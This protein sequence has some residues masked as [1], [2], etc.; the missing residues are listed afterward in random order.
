MIGSFLNIRKISDVFLLMK[1]TSAMIIFGLVVFS[2]LPLAAAE[3]P[4]AAPTVLPSTRREMKTAGFWVS[5]NR[6]PDR[7]VLDEAAV[8]RLNAF[9]RDELKSVKDLSL[10]PAQYSGA[11]LRRELNDKISELGQK[12]YFLEDGRAAQEDF[13]ADVR[14]KSD[15]ESIPEKINVSYGVIVHFADQRFLPTEKGLTAQAGDVDFDE[16]QNSDLDVSTPVVV[17]HKSADGQWLYT[18]SD[19]SGGW[20]RSENIALYSREEFNRFLKPKRFAVV[21]GAKVDIFL[22]SRH[23]E[24]YDYVRMGARLVHHGRLNKIS[25]EVELPTRAQDGKLKVVKGYVPGDVWTG[26]Q[27]YLLFSVRTI[28]TQAFKLLNEPYGWGG[29]NGEQDCSRFLQEVFATVGIHLPRDSKEQAKVGRLLGEFNDETT[30]F[31]KLKVLRQA[32]GGTTILPLKG[33][34]MLYLGMVDNRPYAIHALWAYREDNNGEDRIR[35]INRVAVTDLY[36]GEGSKKGSLLHRLI[37]VR[38]IE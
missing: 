35:V 17:L 21:T 37:A 20:V 25:V 36:L 19:I 18:L 1:R 2:S 27:G 31:D 12:G 9:I 26:R 10:V 4:S 15:L 38:A 6:N 7:V 34:I 29:M 33:H 3:M 24:Y 14:R 5:L 30:D 16:L 23:R 32:Q 8:K 28:L 22:D 13:F 11:D